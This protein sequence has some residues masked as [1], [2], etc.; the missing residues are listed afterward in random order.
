MFVIFS[1]FQAFVLFPFFGL[2]ILGD[3]LF[4][5]LNLAEITGRKSAL[6][7]RERKRVKKKEKSFK[8]EQSDG[9]R[10]TTFKLKQSQGFLPVLTV[11][12]DSRFM[13][14]TFGENRA[15][16]REKVN[17]FYTGPQKSD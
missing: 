17:A 6:I 11:F 9:K 1:L 8:R 4:D 3:V 10:I 16:S 14:F 12:S 2:I 5:G 13:T 7:E 15:E